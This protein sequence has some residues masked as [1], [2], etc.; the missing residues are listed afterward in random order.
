M[1]KDVIIVWLARQTNNNVSP[2]VLQAL[3]GTFIRGAGEGLLNATQD[4]ET[5]FDDQFALALLQTRYDVTQDENG[6]YVL[7]PKSSGQ[8]YGATNTTTPPEPEATDTT[9]G[10]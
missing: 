5:Q 4:T 6:N 3:V 1:S 8:G 2:E 10:A 9:H 7:A